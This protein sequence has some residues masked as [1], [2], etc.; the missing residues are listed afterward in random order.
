MRVLHGSLRAF[1]RRRP[2]VSGAAG[3]VLVTVLAGGGIAYSAIPSAGGVITGCYQ[4]SSGQLR[5]VDAE[6]GQS[7]GRN[8]LRVTWN[9]T[10]PQGP[11]GPQGPRGEIG[12]Q[13]P[14]GPQGTQG[15]QGP[16]GEI[17]PQG[18][19]GPQGPQGPSGPGA[20]YRIMKYDAVVPSNFISVIRYGCPVG[21]YAISGSSRIDAPSDDLGDLGQQLEMAASGNLDGWAWEW[22]VQNLGNDEVRLRLQVVCV[23][24]STVTG[25]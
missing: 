24:S 20:T 4:Q 16:Q 8:E 17:G 21:E 13:G 1:V 10:G 5:V 15:Q 22:V 23:P 19:A 14:Q 9:Q 18:P 6:A 7:C 2:A 11:Q 3:A 25:A 12:P